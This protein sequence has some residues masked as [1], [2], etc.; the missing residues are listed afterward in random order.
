MCISSLSHFLDGR[1]AEDV[2]TRSYHN[3]NGL[4][5]CETSPGELRVALD[6]EAQRRLVPA[7]V[8]MGMEGSRQVVKI[9]GDAM[10]LVGGGSGLD[11]ARPLGDLAHQ[12]AFAGIVQT[13]ERGAVQ[14]IDPDAGGARLPHDTAAAC[15]T[16]LHVPDRVIA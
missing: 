10:G 11:L 16:I 3:S 6:D 4:Y 14:P 1:D 8:P 5:Q 7:A 9:E 15:M 13:V 12:R 2:E